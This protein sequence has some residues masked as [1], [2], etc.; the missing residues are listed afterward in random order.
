MVEVL[1]GQIF[2]KYKSS[3]KSLCITNMATYT[4]LPLS[5]SVSGKR[6]L[7]SA[8]VS[9]SATPIHTTP[10]GTTSIDEIWLYAYN[11]TTASLQVSILWGGTIEPNDV[12]RTTIP[13]KSGR[14]LLE[15]GHLLQNGLTV[16]AYAQVTNWITIDGFV[17]RAQ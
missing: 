7:I 15:D 5:G 9:A 10:V 4:K 11:E 14:V 1:V 2:Y 6:I 12:V 16:S 17:N 13:S 8:T 3:P